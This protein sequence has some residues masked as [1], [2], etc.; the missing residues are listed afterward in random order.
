M[1][2]LYFPHLDL[3]AASWV[4][5]ALLFFDGIAVIAPDG[6]VLD[7]HGGRTRELVELG[8]VRP[9]APRGG[10][11]GQ[12]DEALVGYLVGRAPSVSDHGRH[13]RIHAGKL[14]YAP[15]MGVLERTGLL[16]RVEGSWLEGP[17]WVV[18]HLMSYLALQ[19]SSASRAPMSLVTDE[20]AAAAA[21]VGGGR[22]GARVSRRVRAV[23]TLLPAPPE[24]PPA[25]I[26][27]FR[28]R[29]RRELEIFRSYVDGLVTRDPLDEEGEA[30]FRLRLREAERVREHL[31]GEVRA[32]DWRPVA[33]AIGISALS[34][35]AAPLDHAPWTFAAGL[36]GLAALGVQAGGAARRR[37]AAGDGR[38]IYSTRV[39]GHFPPTAAGTL[40]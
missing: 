33:T 17:E 7:L 29:H 16:A 15:V 10:W 21:M 36:V 32:A 9:V 34:A 13:A 1:E 5:P 20:R 19:I 25:E 6:A 28:E 24:V 30:T 39:V 40:F 18:A 27:D 14:A 4:N 31:A 12:Q 37:H 22:D 26:A 23:A 3:P 38:L 35:A 8:M 2:A 11:D